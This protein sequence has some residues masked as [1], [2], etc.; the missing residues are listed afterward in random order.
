MINIPQLP[1]DVVK[2]ILGFLPHQ[3][4]LN[5][6][7]VCK[8]WERIINDWRFLTAHF[9]VFKFNNLPQRK[10][11]Q[12]VADMNAYEVI[13]KVSFK[14][15]HE[16]RNM[17]LQKLDVKIQKITVEGYALNSHGTRANA[18]IDILTSK[19]T[20]PA[21]VSLKNL[22]YFH[23]VHFLQMCVN[24][25]IEVQKLK[26]RK[27]LCSDYDEQGNLRSCI[28]AFALNFLFSSPLHLDLGKENW[29]GDKIISDLSRQGI[30]FSCLIA[31]GFP[32]YMGFTTIPEKQLTAPCDLVPQSPLHDEFQD[33]VVSRNLQLKQ[34]EAPEGYKGVRCEIFE[35]HL[36]SPCK[37]AFKPQV[38]NPTLL[39]I[40][41][42]KN[43]I[44]NKLRLF[45]TFCFSPNE[46]SIEIWT[47][48]FTQNRIKSLTLDCGLALHS[49]FFTCFPKKEIPNNRLQKL[50]LG[51]IDLNSFVQIAQ[52]SLCTGNHFSL[53]LRG[54]D[55]EVD[56]INH[57]IK[58][59]LKFRKL[60]YFPEDKNE[61]VIKP[62]VENGSLD[63][64]EHL[65]LGHNIVDQLI[66]L[67]ILSQRNTNLKTLRCSTYRLEKGKIVNVE[68]E[69][70]SFL[71]NPKVFPLLNYMN[72]DG[73]PLL[74]MKEIGTKRPAIKFEESFALTDVDKENRLNAETNRVFAQML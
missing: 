47:N 5:N 51:R 32:S 23:A 6:K 9:P 2:Q 41:T 66:S 65:H 18:V 27:I 55:F 53:S 4:V 72:V 30:K 35:S 54:K 68:K 45:D 74:F 40:I 36:A 34:F 21:S 24:H 33:S 70:A 7:R 14:S 69:M 31:K 10:T 46:N 43:L 3:F 67:Q 58:P 12:L 56:S 16:F 25:R 73:E 26:L 57:L 39:E 1:D 28:Y 15:G 11:A 61:Y 19:L 49:K 64:C 17:R 48:F 60:E 63:N 52:S 44:F 37:V 38:L 8:R 62:L 59:N 42:R 13:P 29:V 50:K 20:G 71:S 22:S